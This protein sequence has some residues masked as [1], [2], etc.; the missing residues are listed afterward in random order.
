MFT[1]SWYA[2]KELL[3]LIQPMTFSNNRVKILSEGG[4]CNTVHSNEF[5]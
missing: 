3:N 4:Y 2:I 1:E 5:K